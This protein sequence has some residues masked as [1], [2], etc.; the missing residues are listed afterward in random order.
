MA[1][2]N[3][4][5]EG[6]SIYLRAMEP[7]DVGLLYQWENDPE[8]WPLS[9]TLAPYSRHLLQQYVESENDIFANKQLRLIICL[10]NEEAIGAIDLFDFSPLHQRAGLGILIASDHHRSQGYGS[11]ALELMLSYSFKIL[12]L[13]QVHCNVLTDNM[14]SRKLFE[15]FGFETTGTKKQWVRVNGEWKDECMMQLTRTNWK[16]E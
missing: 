6:A 14:S 16:N 4:I 2:I 1:A 9:T 3:G 7:N 13:N 11:E 8:V 12:Q 10:K 5:L 15:K